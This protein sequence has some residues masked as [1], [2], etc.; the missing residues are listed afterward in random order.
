MK[1]R[2][3]TAVEEALKTVSS[4]KKFYSIPR[5]TDEDMLDGHTPFVAADPE[6]SHGIL[7]KYYERKADNER[8]CLDVGAGIGRVSAVLS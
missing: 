4:L 7:S 5:E 8:R 2:R 1:T 6:H 3:Q